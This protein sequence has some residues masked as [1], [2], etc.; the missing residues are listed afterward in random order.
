M[1]G[2]SRSLT[3]HD[4]AYSAAC[5]ALVAVAAWVTVPI[6]P[7]PFTLQTMAIAF[8]VAAMTPRR[9]VVSLLGYLLL[10]AVGLPVFSGMQGGAG[11]L[12]G[13]T[14]GFLIA[15]IPASVVAAMIVGDGSDVRRRVAAAYAT[16][17]IMF[18]VG[19]AW[20]AYVGGLDPAQAFAAGVAPFVVPDL[21]KVAAGIAVAQA[22][23]R[24]VPQLGRQ[25]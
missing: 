4:I 3:T 11:V 18:L 8:V 1:A 9:I 10:G 22:V 15:L 5:I 20:L 25:A 2:E 17:A 13:M 24:A 19:W 6:G 23:A 21:C 14:G 12:F 7:V 16:D